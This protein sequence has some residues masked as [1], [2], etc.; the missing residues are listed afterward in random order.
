MAKR[1]PDPQPGSTEPS[2]SWLEMYKLAIEM[3]DRVSARRATANTFFSGLNT[4]LAAFISGLVTFRDPQQPVSSMLPALFTIC[5]SGLV[6]SVTW[7]LLLRSYRRLNGAKFVV[8]HQ[9]E[10]LSDF[11][12]FTV[13]WDQLKGRRLMEG[14]RRRKLRYLELGVVEQVVPVIFALIYIITILLVWTRG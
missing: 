14:I 13:E 4:G 3:A 8:I 11:K 10:Q 2:G 5:A 9:L 1:D 6:L 7:W 12:L